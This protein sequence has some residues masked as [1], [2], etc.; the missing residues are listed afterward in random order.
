MIKSYKA[1]QFKEDMY[2]ND[3]TIYS[4]YIFFLTNHSSILDLKNEFAKWYYERKN[5]LNSPDRN[6]KPS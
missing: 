2:H 6:E 1:N 5:A 3:H 4:K